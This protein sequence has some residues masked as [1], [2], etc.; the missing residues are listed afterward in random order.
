MRRSQAILTRFLSFAVPMISVQTAKAD[1]PSAQNQSVIKDQPVT[2]TPNYA[3]L[4]SGIW[5]LALSYVPAVV[6]AVRS[7]REGD[8]RLYIPVAGPWLDLASRHD[9]PTS[10]SCGNE[11]TYKV[12]IVVDGVFQALGAFNIVSAFI[13]PETRTETVSAREP[14]KPRLFELS[15]RVLPAQL[16]HNAYGF[17][18]IGRF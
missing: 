16:G 1:G 11:T 7:D 15:L 12:L 8:Q 13:F 10:V 2:T 18:A 3:L 17:A 14:A 9:C 6:V 5:I 4:R